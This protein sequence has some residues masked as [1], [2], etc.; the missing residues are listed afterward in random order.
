MTKLCGGFFPI[1]RFDPQKKPQKT[2]CRFACFSL[3]LPLTPTINTSTM[4]SFDEHINEH[5]LPPFHMTLGALTYHPTKKLEI[6]YT[7][8]TLESG[9]DL[10]KMPKFT[11]AVAP[12]KM[13]VVTRT[14]DGKET[15][16]TA[17]PN[18]YIMS[19]ATGEKYVVR[20]TKFPMLYTPIP[21]KALGRVAI[22]VP[23]QTPKMVGRYKGE[24]TIVF[25]APWGE[26]MI[27]KQGDYVVKDGTGYYRIA[28]KEFEMTY[29]AVPA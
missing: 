15:Q 25:K 4:K 2:A 3:P 26:S 16:N 20:A 13:V 10:K 6:R 27:L 5:N 23:N 21:A 29:N 19:G 24:Q 14:S 22:V 9:A 17:E 8:W 7:H 1:S 18:D 28:K 12:C 11:Y